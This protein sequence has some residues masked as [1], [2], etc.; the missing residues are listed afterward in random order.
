[1]H[2]KRGLRLAHYPKSDAVPDGVT[3]GWPL[4]RTEI[5]VERGEAGEEAKEDDQIA[6]GVFAGVDVVLPSCTEV[7]GRERAVLL[8]GALEIIPLI[9]PQ[10]PLRRAT[11]H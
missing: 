3:P 1:M 2:W 11:P 7:R 10:K 5:E 8:R 4:G 6:A 9:E